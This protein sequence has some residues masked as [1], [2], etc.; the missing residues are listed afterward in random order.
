MAAKTFRIGIA[1]LGTVGG[2]VVELIRANKKILANRA[3]RDIEI[4][5]IAA[6]DKKKKRGF[7]VGGY[8][9]AGKSEDLAHRPGLDAVV[10]LIGG[11]EG[12]ARKLVEQSLKNGRHVVTANKALIAT[13]GYTLAALAEKNKAGLLFEAAAAGSIPVVKAL[14]ES[15]AGNKIN[16]VYGILNGT[17]NY[18]LTQM[19][20]TGQDFGTVLKEAQDKGYAEA[21]PSFDVDGID[22][23]HKLAI[24]AALA[25]GV[26]PDF[27]AV[28][29]DGIRK[30][31]ATDINFAREL[32][33]KIKLLGVA[34]DYNGKIAQSVEPCLVPAASSLGAVENVF[35]AVFLD[36]DR[37]GPQLLTG[38]GAGAGP[39]ASAVVA[40]IVDLARGNMIP[41]FG[42]PA[43]KLKTAKAMDTGKTESRFYLRMTV[44]DK[45]GVVASVAAILRDHN[46]SMESI[47]QR[48][49]DPGQKVNVVLT[50]HHAFHADMK[51]AVKAITALK[52]V[53][54]APCLLRVVELQS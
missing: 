52:A 48:G 44:L 47:L 27:K 4:S 45:P 7:N 49:H 46:I 29:L 14:R 22:T 25:F 28:S 37:A 5:A 34:R 9:W 10:E 13:H 3:G 23:G 41:A 21:D 42:V 26:K 30:I 1:G 16:A 2:G 50:T 39:T 15:Y 11:A 18:I 31:T 24:L 19:R 36:A 8:D 20:E 35:N 54:G 51:A 17:C 53:S 12:P 6:R 43:A 40:D 32:G 33:Y 38:R